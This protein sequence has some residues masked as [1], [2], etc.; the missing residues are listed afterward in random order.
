MSQRLGSQAS[1]WWNSWP[2]IILLCLALQLITR[3]LPWPVTDFVLDDWGCLFAASGYSSYSDLLGLVTQEASRPIALW[4]T[5]SLFWLLGD[6]PDLFSW[7][8]MVT[9]SMALLVLMAMAY[10][11]TR[12]KWVTLA[13]GAFFALLPNLTESFHWG[14]LIG[15]SHMLIANLV[16]LYALVKYAKTLSLSWLGVALLAYAWATFTYEAGILLPGALL[17][18]V[19]RHTWW[20]LLLA[21]IPFGVVFVVYLLWRYTGAFGVKL[22]IQTGDYTAGG[23][24]AL[25]DVVWNIRQ[26]ISWWAGANFFKALLQGWDGFALIRPWPRVALLGVNL[27]C[28]G[29]LSVMLIRL[30]RGPEDRPVPSDGAGFSAAQVLLFGFAVALLC[31]VLQ[32]LSWTAGRLNFLPGAGLCLAAAAGARFIPMGF[33]QWL[34][35]PVALC[36]CLSNQGTVEQWHR[37]GELNRQLYQHIQ[38]SADDWRSYEVV[39]FDTTALRQR[40]TKGLGRDPSSHLETW[41]YYGNAGLIRGFSP[42]SMLGLVMEGEPAPLTVLDV[43]CGAAVRP[44]ALYW[45]ERWNPARPQITPRERV[46]V[47]DVLDVSKSMPLAAEASALRSVLSEPNPAAVNP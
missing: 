42:M 43:E 37:A 7:I 16:V 12:S 6:R 39:L 10:E 5:N 23:P 2:T 9:H 41:A 3:F 15:F 47:M 29:A 14:Q 34:L 21:M 4:T 19:R 40:L 36:C 11:L 32:F 18:L 27:F 24:P 26:F 31:G 1:F 28:I 22:H 44:D 30:K 25:A 33:W 17:A 35:P 38:K 45:H 13:S 20:R 8:S 46:Y